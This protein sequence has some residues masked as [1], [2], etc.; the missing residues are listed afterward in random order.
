MLLQ[1]KILFHACFTLHKTPEKLSLSELN[2]SLIVAF[3]DYLQQKRGTNARS[4][5]VR[6][7]AIHS[8]YHY[9]A[10]QAPSCSGL[11]IPSMHYECHPIAFLTH[12]EIEV[13]LAPID[14]KTWFGRCCY[15]HYKQDSEYL[16]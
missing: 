4:R 15:W 7:A 14:Q 12:Y 2:A 6:L 3:L 8:F 10:L 13:L 9:V 11:I 1:N 5:N 16:S